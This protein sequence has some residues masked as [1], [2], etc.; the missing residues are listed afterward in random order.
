MKKQ[1]PKYH[2]GPDGRDPDGIWTS[3]HPLWIWGGTSTECRLDVRTS[4]N[5]ISHVYNSM[6]FET[7]DSEARLPYVCLKQN[8]EFIILEKHTLPLNLFIPDPKNANIVCIECEGRL[9]ESSN[10]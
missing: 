10:M 7:I 9:P 3:P 6:I 2:W 5:C 4:A 1:D 8:V